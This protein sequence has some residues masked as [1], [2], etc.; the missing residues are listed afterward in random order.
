MGNTS[1]DRDARDFFE[2]KKNQ[3]IQDSLKR[4]MDGAK[5][6][7]DDAAKQMADDLKRAADETKRV[8]DLAAKQIADDLKRAADE[9]KRLAD[10]TKCQEGKG[11]LAIHHQGRPR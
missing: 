10:E 11:K 1:S 9:T 4:G 7:A 8:A 2:G 5:R 6:V 3:E